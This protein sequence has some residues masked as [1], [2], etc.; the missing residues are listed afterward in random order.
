MVS[1]AVAVAFWDVRTSTLEYGAR[2]VA[3][4]AVVVGAKAVVYVITNSISIG[5]IV[6][7]GSGSICFT[8][9]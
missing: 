7:D 8:G 6:D 3:D 1:V 2:T 9:T 4:A 5:I